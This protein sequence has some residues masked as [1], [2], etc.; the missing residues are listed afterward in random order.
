MQARSKAKIIDGAE[1]IGQAKLGSLRRHDGDGNNGK[2]MNKASK[3]T[4]VKAIGLLGEA[5]TLH[6]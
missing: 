6:I 4:K 3:F 5:S 1:V 2:T